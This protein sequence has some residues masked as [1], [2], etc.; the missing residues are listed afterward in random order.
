[1]VFSLRL[2]GRLDGN[3]YHIAGSNYWLIGFILGVVYV[4]GH[5][6]EITKRDH[7]CLSADSTA[8]PLV[9]F[10]AI[11]GYSVT[12]YFSWFKLDFFGLVFCFFVSLGFGHIAVLIYVVTVTKLLAFVMRE[13]V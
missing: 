2:F 4:I 6:F 3:A 11:L 9:L 7:C 5:V 10:F 13:K 1:M 12:W 8:V